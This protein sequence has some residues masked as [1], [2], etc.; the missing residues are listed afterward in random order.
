MGITTSP[1]SNPNFGDDEV[2]DVLPKR[3]NA[4]TIDGD[5]FITLINDEEQHS[6]LLAKKEVPAGW[7]A[8]GFSGSKHEVSAYIDERWTDIRPASLRRAMNAT[9]KH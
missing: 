1:P 2:S 7:K 9:V 4:Y 6:L 8:V 3:L 5:F